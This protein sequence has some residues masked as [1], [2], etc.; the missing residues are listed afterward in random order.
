M[1]SKSIEELRTLS[2]ELF[3]K[4]PE[5]KKV[6]AIVDGHLFFEHAR[7]AA[8][9]HA[10]NVGG[11]R[12]LTIH[13]ITREEALGV[14]PKDPVLPDSTEDIIEKATEVSV[15]TKPGGGY[16]KFGDTTLGQGMEKA[17][18]F[19]DENPDIKKAI[20]DEVLKLNV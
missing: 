19:L 15:I 6:L 1:R 18:A 16:L 2:K 8:Q 9:M 4:N 3:I 20:V 14:I 7:N 17:I 5:C 13:E 10:R 11:D 12:P